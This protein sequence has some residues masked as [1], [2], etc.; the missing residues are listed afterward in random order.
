MAASTIPVGLLLDELRD[1]RD[2]PDLAVQG[3]D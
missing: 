3:G 1:V 2:L